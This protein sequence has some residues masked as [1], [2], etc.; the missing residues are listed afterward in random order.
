MTLNQYKTVLFR[1]LQIGASKSYTGKAPD[2]INKTDGFLIERISLVTWNPGKYV[3]P[4]KL[5]RITVT[6]IIFT[7]D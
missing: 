4:I 7:H 2:L 1:I 3:L 6:Q 5:A